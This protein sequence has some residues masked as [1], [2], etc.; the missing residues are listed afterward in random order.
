MP[1]CPENCTCGRH[2]SKGAQRSAEVRARISAAKMGH[3]VSAETRARISAAGK[4]RKQSAEHARSR[5]ESRKTHGHAAKVNGR[6]S[7]EYRAWDAMKQRCHNPR[8]R[9]YAQYGA[10]G[11]Y[12]CDR[13]RNSFENFLA[14]M[15]PRPSVPGVRYSVDRIDND[16]PY[17][18]ENCRW[19]TMSEQNR[20]RP[21]FNPN[22]RG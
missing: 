5:A 22:K 3:E 10:R 2:R 15:G 4:G 18:P 13:W 11:I 7:P 16:G 9:Q 6:R 14:D 8:S 12:V 19:A 20:N 17:S 1:K 21:N